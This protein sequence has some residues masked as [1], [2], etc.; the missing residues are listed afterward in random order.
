[1][2]STCWREPSLS[3]WTRQACAASRLAR[4]ARGATSA[5][6]GAAGPGAASGRPSLSR[7]RRYDAFSSVMPMSCGVRAA[8]A[9]V[10]VLGPPDALLGSPAG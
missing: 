3:I 4:G 9:L 6:V 1:M 5:A 8:I 10:I 7:P 2:H